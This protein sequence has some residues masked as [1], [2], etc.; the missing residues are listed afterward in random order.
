MSWGVAYMGRIWGRAC[1]HVRRMCSN[2]AR[3]T[4]VHCWNHG[5]IIVH[6]SGSLNQCFRPHS[7][8]SRESKSLFI[9]VYK[10]IPRSTPV[11][12]Q[13]QEASK[14]IS[15]S[16]CARMQYLLVYLLLCFTFVLFSRFVISLHFLT[17]SV[18]LTSL[19]LWNPTCVW[20]NASDE[21]W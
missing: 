8:S 18:R 3:Q 13:I 7:R 20:S 19:D 2:W 1:I 6:P 14:Q 17:I 9:E 5:L 21:F 10:E 4:N 11:H 12:L 15:S 16:R